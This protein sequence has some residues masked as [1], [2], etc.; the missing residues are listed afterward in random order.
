MIV[1]FRSFH[2]QHSASLK[3]ALGLVVVA[4]LGLLAFLL[5]APAMPRSPHFLAWHQVLEI[6][7]VMIA[8]LIFA[9][10]WSTYALHRQRSILMAAGATSA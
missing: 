3:L 6:L 4:L 10:G 2:P 7:A 8:G 9:V 5:A 1:P